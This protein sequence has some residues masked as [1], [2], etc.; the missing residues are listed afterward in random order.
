SVDDESNLSELIG[1]LLTNESLDILTAN[2]YI[3]AEDDEIKSGLTEEE[4]L[5]MAEN[6]VN[7]TLKFLYEQGPEF[8][9]VEEEVRILRKLHKR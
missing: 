1:C 9:E 5:E 4:I 3:H 6:C 2:E 8:G 7:K